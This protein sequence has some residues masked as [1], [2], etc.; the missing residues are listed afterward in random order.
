MMR[1]HCFGLLCLLAFLPLGLRGQDKWCVVDM[2]NPT[3]PLTTVDNVCFLLAADNTPTLTVVCRDGQLIGGI[4]SVGFRQ[5]DVTGVSAPKIDAEIQLIGSPVSESISILG[6][7]EGTEVRICDL[8]GHLLKAAMVTGG[9]LTIPVGDLKAGV[10][11]LTAGKA[12][13]KFARK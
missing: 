10:Y 11:L 7:P 3:T 13:I 12:T 6:C 5:L 8:A 9:Q 4:G 2:D 1:K